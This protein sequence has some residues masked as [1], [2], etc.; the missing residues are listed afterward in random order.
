L[1][2]P[3]FLEAR[4]VLAYLSFGSEFPTLPFVNALLARGC[5]LAL[6]K[7][8]RE[9]RQLAIYLVKA[10]ESDTTAG[11]WGI[12]EPDPLRCAVADLRAID[13]VLV[14]GVA[15]SRT[16]ERLGYGGGYYDRLLG[17]WPERPP[18]VAAAFELQIC[19][20][21]PVGPNDRPV[22]LVVTERASYRRAQP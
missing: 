21:L 11:V 8:D 4:G 19:D 12:R 9:K 6:P 18:L 22:D 7:V 15:F 5:E 3:A 17:G 1:A 20:E 14:P 2:L 10:L 16:C 13:A